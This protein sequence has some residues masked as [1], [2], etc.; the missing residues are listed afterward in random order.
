MSDNAA[1]PGST[2]T[3]AAPA[4]AATAADEPATAAAKKVSHKCKVLIIG[5]GMAG[6]SAAHHLVKN[7]LHDFKILEARSRIGGRIISIEMSKKK[8]RV[9]GRLSASKTATRQQIHN[10]YVIHGRVGLFWFR[11]WLLARTRARIHSTH[12]RMHKHI[13][14]H[15]EYTAKPTD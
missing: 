9:I 10:I 6:L 4:A 15:N 7:G 11:R 8:V 3:T 13:C 14:L 2:T 12:M 5:A 1:V